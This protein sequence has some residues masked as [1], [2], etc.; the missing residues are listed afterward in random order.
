[1]REGVTGVSVSAEAPGQP[2]FATEQSI[3][4]IH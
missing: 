4:E 2:P 3:A 1:L